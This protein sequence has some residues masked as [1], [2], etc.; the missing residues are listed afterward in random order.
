MEGL[1]RPYEISYRFDGAAIPSGWAILDDFFPN[2]RTGFRIAEYNALLER[3]A[4]LSI[5]STLPRFRWHH[6]RYA[7]W[8]PELAARVKSFSSLDASCRPSFAYVNFINNAFEFLPFLEQWKTPFVF[9]LY[10]GGGFGIDEAESDRKLDGVCASPFLRHVIVT[11]KLTADYLRA[12]HPKV[13]STLVFGSV[14]NPLYFQPMSEPRSWFGDGKATFD[15]CFVGEKYMAHGRSKG[16]PV[17]IDASRRVST[18]VPETRL[19]VVGGYSAD[20]WPLGDLVEKTAFHGRLTTQELKAFYG[21]MDVIVSPNVPFVLH[22]GNFDGFP[23][24]ACAEASLC[25]VAMV[26]SDVLALNTEYEPDD[27]LIIVTPEVDAV[28]E[29]IVR[30][31][32]DPT[33]LRSVAL[34]GQRKSRALYA[35]ERQISPR[36]A[37]IE[38]EARACGA[39]L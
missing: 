14:A 2:L 13:P 12:R 18:A 15:V 9:T 11:Q 22:T 5:H 20:D 23:T 6:A 26:V 36:V 33:R 4:R 8:Y 32:R 21:S 38:R 28:A 34:A 37:V 3:F 27:E 35:P 39:E 1:R 17:F 29:A 31:A 16:Y 10:P 19:H 25:G 24:A 30:L 7:R